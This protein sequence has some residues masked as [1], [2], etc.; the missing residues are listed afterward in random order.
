MRGSHLIAVQQLTRSGLDKDATFF[1]S[2]LR[3]SS[4]ILFSQR[5]HQQTYLLVPLRF[6]YPQLPHPGLKA[7]QLMHATCSAR[8]CAT[9]SRNAPSTAYSAANAATAS[10]PGRASFLTLPVNI[11]Q[12]LEAF[13]EPLHRST[14][15]RCPRVGLRKI[16]GDE[17]LTILNIRLC[18]LDRRVLN[19]CT[20]QFQLVSQLGY[21]FLEAFN[22]KRRVQLLVNCG[23]I[24]DGRNT[25]CE[26][27]C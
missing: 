16:L 11:S 21:L 17:L 9:Y 6:L 2:R 22:E 1:Y 5:I 15:E 19:A 26:G 24:L 4:F 14:H 8:A 3:L 13:A 20:H 12:D 23:I 10:T 18:E 7:S 27:A 25:L